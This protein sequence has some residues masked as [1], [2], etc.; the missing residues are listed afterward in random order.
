MRLEAGSMSDTLAAP[1]PPAFRAGSL[2]R[3]FFAVL[4]LT[5]LA[6]WLFYGHRPGV[7]VAVFVLALCSCALVTNR[8]ATGRRLVAA[9]LLAP[10]AVLPLV[11]QPGI[12][13]V[14]AAVV[15]LSAF[16]LFATGKA[17]PT[18]VAMLERSARL[19][20][21][22]PFRLMPDLYLMNRLFRRRRKVR[23]RSDLATGW[24]VPLIFGAVFVALLTGANPLIEK[25]LSLIDV[26][27]TVASFDVYR[28]IFWF[29]I[30]S[31]TWP[32]LR[33]RFSKRRSSAAR[34]LA[35]ATAGAASEEQPEPAAMTPLF[36]ARSI[37]RS[38][39]LFN[40][41]FALQTGLDLVYLWGGA[42]LPEGMTYAQY[43]H[44]GAYMLMAV[45]LL[46]GTFVLI[47]MHPNGDVE[48][49]RHIRLLVFAWLAQTIFLVLSAMRRL[50]LYVEAYALTQWRVAALIWMGLV[51]AGLALIAFR[52]A[53][54]R[55]N[56]WLVSANL[57]MLAAVVYVCALVNF[58]HL[59]ATYNV[60]H[61][62]EVSG[63]GTRLDQRYLRR[64]GPMAIP[65]LDR[66]IAHQRERDAE[67]MPRT[68]R[69]RTR[70]AAAHVAEQALNW[71]HWTFRGWRLSRYLAGNLPPG[72][73]RLEGPR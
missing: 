22:G 45:A 19:L 63:Q 39:V 1:A 60:D 55:S 62:L 42:D 64:L 73:D 10:L 17:A 2:E 58:P 26:G 46:T 21:A 65:A 7:S 14:A 16:A 30:S 15:C 24:L 41:L 5:C 54:R 4:A 20:V 13:S 56:G 66:F 52:I 18:P 40:L 68:L 38:L 71:R 51:A 6:D 70:A 31:V 69:F 47:S 57:V 37:Y 25:M 3:Q 11:E 44:R 48:R 67:V 43:A 9:C 33:V 72:A 61:S 36:N 23:N 27:G 49:S 32:F 28:V 59:I 50:D 12:L 34:E 29:L 53:R 35:V 8:L